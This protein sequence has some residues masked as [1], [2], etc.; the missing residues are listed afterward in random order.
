MELDL[1]EKIYS[2]QYR[3]SNSYVKFYYRFLFPNRSMLEM[4]SPEEFYDR[5]ISSSFDGA[6]VEDYGKICRQVLA[7]QLPEGMNVEQW[8]DK[9]GFIDIISVDDNANRIVGRCIY[10]REA[11]IRDYE[12]LMKA[13][14][15][16]GI[17]VDRA[18]IYSEK[19]YTKELQSLAADGRTELRGIL[20]SDIT[21]EKKVI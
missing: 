14:K 21:T 2:G 5:K 10:D 20:T 9:D 3:I 16:A 8:R 18:L 19:G 12:Q 1:V 13:A 6:V 4:L 7:S 11:D 15:R 17:L